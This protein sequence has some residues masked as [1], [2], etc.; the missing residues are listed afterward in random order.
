MVSGAPLVS[1]CVCVCVCVRVLSTQRYSQATKNIPPFERNESYPNYSCINIV[2][3]MLS[4]HQK[5]DPMGECDRSKDHVF[6]N[7][8]PFMFCVIRTKGEYNARRKTMETNSS[9]RIPTP[10]I[11]ATTYY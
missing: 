3:H 7:A 11:A 5:E 9:Q 2:L 6:G 4:F 1:V 10:P 8:T